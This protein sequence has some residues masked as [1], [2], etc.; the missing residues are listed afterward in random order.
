MTAAIDRAQT[1]PTGSLS[2]QTAAQPLAHHHGASGPYECL[3]A[4][5]AR[6]QYNVLAA[7]IDATA[8]VPVEDAE[9]D[10]LEAMTERWPELA[11]RSYFYRHPE[12]AKGFTKRYFNPSLTE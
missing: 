4:S 10:W 6:P 5:A 9:L 11:R 1:E 3:G 2:H 12:L 8:L 7:P